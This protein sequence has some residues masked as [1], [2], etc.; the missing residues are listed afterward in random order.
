MLIG[1]HP[2]QSTKNSKYIL[3][4]FT[5]NR[6]ITSFCNLWLIT[7]CTSLGG[8]TVNLAWENNGSVTVWTWLHWSA[9]QV[10]DVYMMFH[11]SKRLAHF[12]GPQAQ[13]TKS[14]RGF[15]LILPEHF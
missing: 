7:I 11:T 5:A 1:L 4:N 9:G 14:A 2:F 8:Y 13:D 3:S 10:I 12:I 6:H 15:W